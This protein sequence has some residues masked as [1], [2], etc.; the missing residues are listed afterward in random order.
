MDMR[1]S[2]VKR[3][4]C[5]L[6][7]VILAKPTNDLSVYENIFPGVQIYLFWYVYIRKSSRLGSSTPY[8]KVNS[9]TYYMDIIRVAAAN[10]NSQ[11]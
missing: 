2:S 10:E 3:E 5:K 4:P 11:T 7:D 1:W 9:H 6:I 8:M